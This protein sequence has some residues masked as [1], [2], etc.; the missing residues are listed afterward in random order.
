MDCPQGS[1]A[2]IEELAHSSAGVLCRAV[3]VSV[4]ALHFDILKLY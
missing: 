1:M 3:A 2:G 4:V